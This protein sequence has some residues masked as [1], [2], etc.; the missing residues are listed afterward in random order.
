MEL[1]QLQM[2]LAVAAEGSLQKAAEKVFRTPPAVSIAMG[3]LEDELGTPIFDRSQGRD[4]RLSAAGE[5]LVGYAKRMLSLRNEAL[6]AIDEVRNAKRGHLRVGANQSIGESLLPKLTKT[7]LER[8]PDVKLRVMIE[9]SDVVL[10]AL[11]HHNLDLALVACQPRDEELHAQL[12]MRDRLVVIMNP[13]HR[14]ADREPIELEELASESLVLLTEPSELRERI[15]ETFRRCQVPLNI[16][17]ETGTLESVKQMVARSTGIG[18]VPRLCVQQEESTGELLVKA[19]K[20]F[21]QERA[22]WV[23]SRTKSV[24]PTPVCQAF[25]KVIKS[26]VSVLTQ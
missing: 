7:F 13:A 15:N 16:R 21:R 18:I 5:V 8:Y 17:I 12:L 22:L 9:Y 6:A 24:D 2:L 10:S 23:V 14:L 4:F 20:E 19:V 26:E 11:K 25:M 3:K 1:M